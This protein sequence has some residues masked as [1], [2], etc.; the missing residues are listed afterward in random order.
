M[1][2]QHPVVRAIDVGYG[3]VKYVAS[4]S[5]GMP[6]ACSLFPS[7][8]PQAAAN[9]DLGSGVFARRNTVPITIGGLRYEV[10][11][12]AEL[13]QD[14]SYGRVL[15]G[16]YSMSDTYLALLRGALYYMRQPVIDMLVLGLPVSYYDQFA[17]RLAERVIGKHS[18]PDFRAEDPNTAPVIE[19]EVKN[20]RV[21]PQPI[22]AFMDH[23]T[24]NGQ[25]NRMRTQMNLL[26]DPGYFTLDWV[27]AKGVKMINSRSGS[28]NGGMS[29]ILRQIAEQIA[30]VIETPQ[31]DVAILD[32]ALSEGCNP[33]FYSQEFTDWP[34]YVAVGKEKARQALQALATKVGS[35][36]DIQNIILAGGGATFFLDVVKEKFPKHTVIVA[37]NPVYANVRGFQLAGTQFMQQAAFSA[38]RAAK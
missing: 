23:S 22:G 28:H 35:G 6:I 33:F 19:V 27:V 36:V 9:G 29:A 21:I 4:H 18:I 5:K 12:D 17:E 16:D 2:Q 11:R 34:K 25:Y 7:L 20:V 37:E 3:N 38:E 24:G 14:M 30:P 8:A 26:I 32:R 10:G 31:I 1:H 15:D 13:A